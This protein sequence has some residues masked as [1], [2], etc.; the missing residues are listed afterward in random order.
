[1]KRPPL[2]PGDVYPAHVLRDEYGMNTANRPT[3]IVN[4]DEVPEALLPLIPYA[5]RWAIPCDVTRGDYFDQQPEEDVAAFWFDVL[6]HVGAINQW[7]DSQPKDVTAWPEAAVHFL[8]LLKAHDDAYQPT[9]EEKKAFR[10]KEEVWAHEQSR[11]GA[12]EKAMDAF[13]RKDYLT[14]VELIAP[15]EAELEKVMKA[16]LDFA[17]KK[18]AGGKG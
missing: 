9:E 11:K 5:E 3:I 2:K 16:K 12:V 7:L 4:K 17:R 10:K 18:L 6:P 15:F 14:M 8:Y 13:T 1:M